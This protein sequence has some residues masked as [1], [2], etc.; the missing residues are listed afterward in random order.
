MLTRLIRSG[1]INKSVIKPIY[2]NNTQ[3]TFSI[4]KKHEE[5]EV[6]KDTP[7]PEKKEEQNFFKQKIEAD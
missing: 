7:K 2:F 5:E 1:A 4:L 3:R 6:S